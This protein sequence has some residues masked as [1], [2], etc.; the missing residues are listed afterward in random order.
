ML[1]NLFENYWA[2]I[3]HITDFSKRSLPFI[4][5]TIISMMLLGHSVGNT[6]FQQRFGT[7]K[8]LIPSG[9][10]ELHQKLADNPMASMKYLIFY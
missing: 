9:R 2:S 6:Q 3:S 10:D 4:F 8:A 1:A 7:K 5:G